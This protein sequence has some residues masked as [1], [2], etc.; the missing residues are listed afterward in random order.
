MVVQIVGMPI[1]DLRE[2]SFLFSEILS[3]ASSVV[4]RGRIVLSTY[5]VVTL[6]HDDI[7]IK[8][9]THARSKRRVPFL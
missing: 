2:F 9:G 7:G 8:C 5:P 6:A 1:P 4:T 3:S